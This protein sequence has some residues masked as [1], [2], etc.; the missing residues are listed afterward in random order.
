MISAILLSFTDTIIRKL[1]H[2]MI[3]PS[4]KFRITP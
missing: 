1:Y 4:S 3:H 2:A